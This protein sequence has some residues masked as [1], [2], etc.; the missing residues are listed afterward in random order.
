MMITFLLII[1]VLS[2]A[3]RTPLLDLYLQAGELIEQGRFDDSA[4]LFEE[5]FRRMPDN[6][7]AVYNI[8]VSGFALGDVFTADSLFSNFPE[9]VF[10]GDTLLE[11]RSSA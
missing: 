10:E 9:N 6:Q 8:A 7:R 1:T 2:S 11:A 3:D 5:I 4:V